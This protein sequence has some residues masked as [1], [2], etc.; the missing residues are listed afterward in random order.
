MTLVMSLHGPD[1][2][3]LIGDR[4]LSCDGRVIDDESNKAAAIDMDDARLACA[5][6]GLA[7]AGSFSTQDWLLDALHDCAPP[8]FLSVPTLQRFRSRLSI[9]F[10][11]NR[12]L[13]NL[14]DE[15]KRL[16][17]LFAGF[18]Y[19]PNGIFPVSA[20][21]TNFSGFAGHGDLPAEPED[22]VLREIKMDQQTRVG[23]I[24]AWPAV[25]KDDI[26]ALN[27][28]LFAGKP[29]KAVLGKAI[30]LFHTIADRPSSHG[31]VGGQL[32]SII[33]RADRG[34]PIETGY[35]V[36]DC[37]PISYSPNYAVLTRNHTFVAKGGMLF[38]ADPDDPSKPSDTPIAVPKV[39][40][41]AYCPCGSKKKYRKCHGKRN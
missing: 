1:Y 16:A 23:F 24:G 14:P 32:N 9:E 27:E 12:Y 37:S 35:H 3:V 30:D 18:H 4:R 34:T 31:A 21:V 8:D 26:A 20:F 19:A 28:M 7:R 33:L 38:A 13:R 2:A 6:T 25:D 10:A 15:S 5:F 40:P 17:V 41:N 11:E 36:R 29:V 22:F 39:H